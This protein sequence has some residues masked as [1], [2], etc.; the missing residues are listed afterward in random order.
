MGYG[1]CKEKSLSL[2]MTDIRSVMYLFFC[3]IFAYA[4]YKPNQK[5]LFISTSL[6]YAVFVSVWFVI[7]SVFLVVPVFPRIVIN[8]NT[9]PLFFAMSILWFLSTLLVR[10]Y[11]H[12]PPKNISE[13]PSRLL[14]RFEPQM[15][16][17][18]YFEI[19]FQQSMFLYIIF[20]LLRGLSEIQVIGWFTI[21]VGVIHLGNIPFTGKKDAMFYFYLSL[22]TAV[23]FGWLI[24]HGYVFITTT[25]HMLFYL[26]FNGRHWFRY[27][28]V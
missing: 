4:P 20:V 17:T 8:R 11:G 12:E 26:V 27:E 13:A 18:K 10:R 16:F 5:K 7:W 9:V 28:N 19:L 24:L 6:W 23:L 15:F 25:L 14:I 21:V 22:P 2:T 3:I 1:D